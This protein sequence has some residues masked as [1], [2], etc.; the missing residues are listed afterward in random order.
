MSSAPLRSPPLRPPRMKKDESF[1]GKLG[2][3]LARKKKAREG[4]CAGRAG[5][6]ARPA[7][8]A[9]PSPPPH[10]RVPASPP[11]RAP[12]TRLRALPGSTRP[13]QGVAPRPARAPVA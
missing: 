3:T 6:P 9:P 1:L 11:R 10:R 5:V 12:R 2:G 7:R 13:P 4:E 8:V